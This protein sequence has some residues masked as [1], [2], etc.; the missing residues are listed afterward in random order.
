[1]KL[2]DLLGL[3][4][5]F[6]F[7]I[8]PAIQAILRRGRPVEPEFEDEIPLPKSRPQPQPAPVQQPQT[9]TA[10]APTKPPAPSQPPAPVSPPPPR[11]LVKEPPKPVAKK[12]K[13]LEE[14]ERERLKRVGASPTPPIP[15]LPASPAKPALTSKPIEPPIRFSIDQRAILNGIVWHQILAEPRGKYWR[16]LRKP[17]P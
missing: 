9:S 16:R 10:P 14:I 12:G 17:K 3:L 13:T 15:P 6:F 11:P 1:M 5:L 2:D 7:V 4:F 8:L